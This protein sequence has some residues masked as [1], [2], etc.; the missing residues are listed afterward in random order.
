L[1]KKQ[2]IPIENATTIAF[3]DVAVFLHSLYILCMQKTV[4]LI[5]FL[6]QFITPQQL[7]FQRLGLS[8]GL[9]QST[10]SDIVQD[11]EG[12]LWLATWDGLV[13]YDGYNFVTY[14]SDPNDS[15]TLSNN[16]VR[17]LF[18]D[19]S[20]FLWAMTQLGLNRFHPRTGEV[21]Q[22][23]PDS[24]DQFSMPSLNIYSMVQRN[25]GK[26]FVG[27]NDGF[28]IYDTTSEQFTNYVLPSVNTSLGNKLTIHG[29]LIESDDIL[30]MGSLDG[31]LRYHLRFNTVERYPYTDTNGKQ[32]G[33]FEPIR[34]TQGKFWCVSSND[35]V[36]VFD[37]VGKNY[38]EPTYKNSFLRCEYNVHQSHLDRD[39]SLWFTSYEKLM[40]VKK[41][42]Q[43]SRSKIVIQEY[44]EFRHDPI[45]SKSL[46]AVS[47]LS[48]R[49]DQSGV[50]W[51]GTSSGLNKS[52]PQR[53]KFVSFGSTQQKI[54]SL[55]NGEIITLLQSGEDTLWIGTREG[56]FLLGR[57]QNT[58]T[59]L[60][61][62][63][64]IPK[65]TI[66]SLFKD[67]EGKLLAGTRDGLYVWNTRLKQFEYKNIQPTSSIYHWRIYSFLEMDSTLWIGSSDG[68]FKS[69]GKTYER[70]EP[71]PFDTSLSKIFPVLHLVKGSTA[72]SIIVCTNGRGIF[73]YD[74]Q[75]R[76]FVRHYQYSKGNTQSLSN[77]IVMHAYEDPNH[78]LWA[79]TYGGGLDKI[80]EIDGKSSYTHYQEKEGLINNNLYCVLPDLYG[81]LW[82]SSNKGISKFEVRTET[83][84][85]YTHQ[86]GLPSNEFNQNAFYLHQTG[87]MFFG[88]VSGFVEF[89]PSQ[90][91]ENTIVPHIAITDFRIFEKPRNE[92]LEHNTIVLPY[93]ENY[94]SFEF[95]SLCFESPQKNR[96]AYRLLGI[97]DQWTYTD[98]RRYASFANL[99]PGEY[100]FQ[101]KGTNNDGIWNETGTSINIR[102]L[103]PWWGTVLFRGA[104]VFLFVSLIIGG[105]WYTSKR[106]FQRSIVEL[107]QQKA[108]LEERQRTREQIARD[109]HD[110]VATTIS[111]I[112]LYAE[113]VHHRS[114]KKRSDLVDAVEK[115]S[116]LS[117]DAKQAMEE[118][119]WSLSPQHDTLNNLVDRIG[120]L[121][122]QWCADHSLQCHLA[123]CIIPPNIM[124]SEEIRKNVYL[125]F[126]E[127]VNNI[128]KHSNASSIELISWY[129]QE[130]FYLTI[131]DNG[132]GMGGESIKKNT[133]GGNGLLNMETRAKTIG[134]EFTVESKKNKGTSISVKVKI[135]QLR[136]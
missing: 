56:V 6:F 57:T 47:L 27:S 107:Q 63:F 92:L 18:Y 86:D 117:S 122:A 46:N 16:N 34:D 85:N 13:R 119:V 123:F 24:L 121:A 61:K 83:F 130:F 118:V 127:A 89:Y 128:I 99:D 109:L 80:E 70:F 3:T 134:A 14:R 41:Y 33:V 104:S 133:V 126:K 131:R 28:G 112:S 52:I 68:F 35:K 51:V 32:F 98:V 55:T 65:T 67:N 113:M 110:D 100:V 88:G 26:I 73:R 5:F 37:P 20:G 93:N 95:A 72:H 43:V 21:K 40:H 50:I 79:A 8:D 23:L 11:K 62:Y 7:Q 60:G 102:I 74:T 105:V 108:I 106:K 38:L 45:N 75:K 48:F 101:V 91:E 9:P 17:A 42:A 39:S 78:T 90:I 115:I 58:Y 132:K 53:K 84:Y 4:I 116:T 114:R 12:F 54:P 76:M 30:W 81:D 77:S 124:I 2:T 103:P 22:F 64:N 120:D 82:M 125:I 94:L 136:H 31:L 1:L 87:K 25:D 49:K 69:I 15:T 44:E 10:V 96:Y 111:S 19:S 71:I 36:V 66:Y 29:I 59:V 129:E 135:A 97:T